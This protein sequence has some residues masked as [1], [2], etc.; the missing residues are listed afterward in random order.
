MSNLIYYYEIEKDACEHLFLCHFFNKT[1]IS[2]V[3]IPSLKDYF[4]TF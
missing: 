3:N 4:A 2:T 1:G